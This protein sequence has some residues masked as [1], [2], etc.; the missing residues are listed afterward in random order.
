MKKHIDEDNNLNIAF[1]SL[2]IILKD[3]YQLIYTINDILIGLLFLLGT[4]FNMLLGWKVLGAVLYICGSI[5]LLIRPVIRTCRLLRVKR[6]NKE[7][8]RF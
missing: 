1:G 5:L 4:I 3:K 7:K 2:A 8:R 6:L